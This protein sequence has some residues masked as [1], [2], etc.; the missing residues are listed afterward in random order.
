METVRSPTPRGATRVALLA[1]PA[2]G[3]RPL[4]LN[5]YAKQLAARPRSEGYLA[6]SSEM[7]TSSTEK[8]REALRRRTRHTPGR[9][10][11]QRQR[12]EE[13]A[14]AVAAHARLREVTRARLEETPLSRGECAA[15]VTTDQVVDARP[16]EAVQE[17]LRS[18][19][20]GGVTQDK[21]RR[22]KERVEWNVD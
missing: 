2:G 3:W 5:A 21:T 6:S 9:R 13:R 11:R 4:N 19:G 17:R 18:S 10:E 14:A 20:V 8:E 7:E 1:K 16:R 22:P 15:A 12:R